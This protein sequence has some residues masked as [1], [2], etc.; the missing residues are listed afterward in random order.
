MDQVDQTLLSLLQREVVQPLAKLAAAVGLSASPCWR[1]VQRLEKLGV[2]KERV[3]LLDRRKLGLN[4][5]VFVEVRFS[6]DHPD[7]LHS[8]EEAIRAAPEVLE[9]FMLMGEVDFLLRV[10]TRDVDHY[11]QFLRSRLAVLPGVR[12]I[13]SSIALSTVKSTTSLPLTTT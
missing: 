5:E 3:A 8:F 1:R 11:E 2:I 6:R 4:L 13:N 12:D 9:C 7:S 10:V